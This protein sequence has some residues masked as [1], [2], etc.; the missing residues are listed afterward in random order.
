LIK[1]RDIFIIRGN[2]N[3]DRVGIAGMA[4]T[5]PPRVLFPDLFIRVSLPPNKIDGDYF[6]IAWNSP[7]TRE[8]LE[9]LAATTSGIWKINQ[10]HIS[11][12]EI[13]L[14]SLAE[15]KRIVVKVNELMALCDTVNKQIDAANDKQVELLNAV[16][17]LM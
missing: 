16:M 4:R 3:K 6:L 1:P 13:P 9:S 5:C 12:C 14:P 7:V 10:G 17:A 15:Q 8:K 11:K 2:G